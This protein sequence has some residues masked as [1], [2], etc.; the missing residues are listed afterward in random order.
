MVNLFASLGSAQST[1]RSLQDGLGV[2][3]NNVANASTPG[4]VKQRATLEALPFQPQLGLVGGVTSGAIQDSRSL[5]AERAVR[6]EISALGKFAQQ[7]E[8]L[9]QL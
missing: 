5:P 7:T 3:Q 6:S 1:L 9:S 8:S 2:S 4:Y